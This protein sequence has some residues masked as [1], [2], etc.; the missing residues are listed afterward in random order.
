MSG[1]DLARDELASPELAAEHYQALL[2]VDRDDLDALR[3]LAEIRASQSRWNEVVGLLERQLDVAPDDQRADIARS[4]GATYRDHLGDAR[5]AIAAYETALEIDE[6]DRETMDALETLYRDQDR[7]EALRT[8][9]ECRA[10]GA[11]DS[12]RSAIQ[13]RLARLC[14]EAFRDPSAAIGILREVLDSDPD[15]LAA[16]TDLERLFEATEAWDDL[17]A[18]ILSRVAEASDAGQREMLQHVAEVH[19]RK[20]GDAE[21]AIRVYERIQSE[22]GPDDATLRALADLYERESRWTR[23]ADVLERLSSRLQAPEA[24]DLCHRVI[25]LYEQ[26]VGDEEQAG[27]ALRAAYERFPS[28][29]RTRKRVVAHHEARNEYE[30]LARVLD[31]ELEFT[32]SDAD[33]VAL[34]RRISDIHRDRLAD[35]GTAANY[36]ERAVELDGSDRG[37]LV[38]LCDLY[39][40]AGREADAVPLLQQIIESFGKRRSKELAAYHHRLGQALAGMGDSAGALQAYDAAFK[41]DLTNVAILRDL[42]KLTHQS[43]D[44]DRAQKSFRALLLQRLEPDS[45]I[46]KADVYYYLGDIAAKQDD[47]RKAITMLERALAEDRGHAQASELLAKLKG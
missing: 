43:G 2:A 31:D 47:P 13:L 5:A 44:L 28:D 12:E 14:E 18:L 4:M 35:P 27:R 23:V 46:Q 38:P 24:V 11:D 42:G 36:L 15:H 32:S 7:L 40:A 3:A 1:Q 8:L 22:L 30:A 26:E 16:Y 37:A 25:D 29:E 6:D 10:G 21:A 41:I 19:D 17:I 33:R 20:R 34:L 45:G 39:V 9:L